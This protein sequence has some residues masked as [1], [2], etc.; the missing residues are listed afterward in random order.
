[1]V[2]AKLRDI[3]ADLHETRGS[4]LSVVDALVSR[5]ERLSSLETKAAELGAASRQFSVRWTSATTLG[6]CGRRLRCAVLALLLTILLGS[7]AYLA[8]LAA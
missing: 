6:P 8:L 7:V 5:G 3:L 4:M 1:M 2:D